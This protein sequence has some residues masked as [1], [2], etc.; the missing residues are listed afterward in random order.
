MRRDGNPRGDDHRQTGERL[1]VPVRIE[2]GGPNVVEL[3]VEAMPDE[4]TAINK[5]AVVTIE[6]VR[7]KLKVLLVSGEPHAGERMWRNLLKSD[8][9]VDLVHFTILRPPEKQDGTPINELSLIAFP[10]ADLFGRK[11][12]EFDLI[13]FDRYSN[14]SVLPMVYFDNIVRYVREGGALLLAAG[15]DF[16]GPDGL[17]LFAARAHRAGAPRGRPDREPV[18]RRDLERG[19]QAPVTR[20]LPGADQTPAGLEPLVPAGQC[21]GDARRQHPRRR[22]PE[23]AAR[24]LARRKGPRRAAAQRPDVAVVARLR[25]RRALP[26]PA[27]PPRALA[28][29]GA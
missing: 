7:D 14:Q 22:R 24:A 27:A 6:G 12:K 1:R 20:G 29:E 19:R 18:P 15:P 5:K 28:D 13:V 17:Y 23:A 4:L 11:I 8:A 26:R 2:H 3:E 16:S 9:N 21:G 10:T 25:G